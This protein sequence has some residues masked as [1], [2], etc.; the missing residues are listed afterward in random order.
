MY[1]NNTEQNDN[2]SKAN[3][4]Q[5]PQVI[6]LLGVRDAKCFVRHSTFSLKAVDILEKR[7]VCSV[8]SFSRL[9]VT[10]M[11]YKISIHTFVYLSNYSASLKT[12]TLQN[13]S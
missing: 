10:M 2:S 5:W 1:T 8:L 4:D 12:K 11:H 3:A 6:D 7:F 9:C 13:S